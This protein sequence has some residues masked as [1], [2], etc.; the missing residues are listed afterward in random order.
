MVSASITNEVQGFIKDF[1]S[2]PLEKLYEDGHQLVIKFVSSQWANHYT[3][4]RNLKI[5]ARPALTWGTAT[6]VTPLIYPLSSALYGRIGL[7]SSYDP[8]GWKVF[9]ATQPAA[10]TA[11][12]KWARTQPAYRD[13]L[14]T[15]HSTYANHLLRDQ[16][17][18]D[19]KI[20]CVLFHP[21][22]AAEAH[23]DIANHVWMA[24]TDWR[25]TDID[26]DLSSRFSQARFSVLVDEDFKILDDKDLPIRLSPR[27]IE[28][29]TNPIHRNPSTQPI[30]ILRGRTAMGLP[31]DIRA[32]Y[33]GGGYI[34]IFIEP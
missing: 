16:F 30:G 22:Q 34:H 20:D 17:R 10:N 25:G 5:S 23:T 3:T 4:H 12:I 21:D 2:S 27:Q 13:L 8:V 15:V 14:L 19:F 11:Y 7:V 28:Q 9:D 32:A 6:Y 1:H 33:T 31:A 24:V 18:K 26:Y 29:A